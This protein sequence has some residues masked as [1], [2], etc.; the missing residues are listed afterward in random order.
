ME[1][2]VNTMV[3]TMGRRG[4][5]PAQTLHARA[6]AGPFDADLASVLRPKTCPATPK[7]SDVVSADR[8]ALAFV[9]PLHLEV[10]R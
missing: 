7:R 10:R 2:A 6:C 9:A 1:Q 4:L 3:E 8:V 5:E